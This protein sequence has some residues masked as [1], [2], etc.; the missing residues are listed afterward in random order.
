MHNILLPSFHNS[1]RRFGCIYVQNVSRYIQI[2][3][4]N[5]GLEGVPK[6]VA[7]MASLTVSCA[8]SNHKR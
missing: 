7:Y 8:P 6:I 3:N 1:Y 4:K 2:Y 5:Y